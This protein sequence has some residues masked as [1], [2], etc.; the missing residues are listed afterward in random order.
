L[1]LWMSLIGIDVGSSTVKAAAY[2]ED[3]MLLALEREELVPCRQQPGMWEQNPNDVWRAASIALRRLAANDSLHRN[4]PRTLAVSASGR[5]NFLADRDGMPLTNAIMGADTRG[6]EFEAA[7]TGASSP[8][9]WTLSCGHMRERMDPVFRLMW[10]RKYHPEIVR[11]ATAYP[12]WHGWLT[13]KLCGRNVSEAT[14]AGRWQIYDLNSRT[15]SL[16][17][18]RANDFPENLLPELSSW[19][20]IIERIRRDLAEELGL[21]PSLNIAVGGHDSCCA[22]LGAGA[23]SLGS[24]CLVSG[25]YENLL[26]S[27]NVLPTASMLVR[28]LSA[29]P[30]FGKAGL[31]IWA[32]SPTGTAVL[33]WTRNLVNLSIQEVDS[34]LSERHQSPSPVTT[35]PYF[36]GSMLYWNDGRKAKGTFLGL[37][38]ATTGIDIV[39]AVMES[40]GYDHANTFSLLEQQGIRVNRIRATGGGTRSLWWTQLKSDMIQ[41]PIEVVDQPEPGTL[42][43]A[44]LAGLAD[45]TFRDLDESSE[46]VSGTSRIHTPDRGRAALHQAR[47]EAYKRAVTNLLS[48]IY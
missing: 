25:S 44:L 9:P 16:E 21:S 13:F 37:T 39:Q 6:A 3:G 36:S 35:V 14:L 32:I 47:L 28:G 18:I 7:P 20:T 30:H 19:G 46:L 5:E 48:N 12:D 8:E 26:V 15:W 45:G 2:Q 41:L 23:L 43:A 38:L 42:G 33:D 11:Q 10:W 17:R 29:T 40:I 22:A 34:Q 1:G 4:P 24:A 27:T 31:A